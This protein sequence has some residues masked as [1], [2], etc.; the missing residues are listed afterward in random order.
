MHDL[1]AQLEPPPGP[2]R[3][4][5]RRMLGIVLP[6]VLLVVGTLIAF[7]MM[8]TSPK[9]RTNPPTRSATLVESAPVKFADR[10]AVISAMGLVQAAKRIVLHPRVT[11]E[12]IEVN[13]DFVP[14]GTFAEGEM[15]L[16]IDPTD[17]DL[18]LRQIAR[19]VAQAEADLRV[20]EGSQEIARKDFE[21][22]GEMVKEKDRDLVLR[23]PQL[24][25]ARASLESARAQL[26]KARVDLERTT[27]KAPFNAVVQSQDVNI[28]AR[29]TEST[30]LAT[31][32]GTDTYW[33][34]A[35]VPVNQ[36]KWIRIPHD[37]SADAGAPRSPPYK[38]R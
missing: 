5:L 34:E 28:G 24:E 14:G 29:V 35:T 37:G 11:G 36:L 22:L 7:W 13:E 12:V 18:A 2:A 9:A 19:A 26:E 31:L 30:P 23:K 32:V 1:N 6:V 33:V 4:P 15:L 17:Y 8:K 38:R 3:T 16:K 25:T 27:V 21:L 20:E 10:A